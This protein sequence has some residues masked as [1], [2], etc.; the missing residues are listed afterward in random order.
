M[1]HLVEK[2][3]LIIQVLST[4]LQVSTI[5]Q[6]TIAGFYCIQESVEHTTADEQFFQKCF[7]HI[8]GKGVEQI[9]AICRDN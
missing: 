7:E 3:I 9:I 1:V 8:I 2:V 4:I 5:L 6:S